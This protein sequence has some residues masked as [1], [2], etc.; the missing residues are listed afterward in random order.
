MSPILVTLASQSDSNF[1]RSNISF[2]ENKPDGVDPNS[3]GFYYYVRK[4]E[5]RTLR[6]SADC[7]IKC[8]IKLYKGMSNIVKDFNYS[9]ASHPCVTVLAKSHLVGCLEL[10]GLKNSLPS[11]K[12]KV[13]DENLKVSKSWLNLFIPYPTWT[14]TLFETTPKDF[15]YNVF[16]LVRIYHPKRV[17]SGLGHAGPN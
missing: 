12:T 1:E 9:I 5:G 7:F 13:L 6:S 10:H 2:K 16:R 11:S 3:N 4:K 14:A 17:W 15:T 8:N